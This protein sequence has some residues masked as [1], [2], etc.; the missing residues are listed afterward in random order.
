MQNYDCVGVLGAGSW[1]STLADLLGK[2]GHQVLLWLRNLQILQEINQHHGNSQYMGNLVL[3]DKITAI[4]DLQQLAQR[5][6]FMVAALP[7]PSLREIAYQLGNYIKGDQIL[8]SVCKGLEPGT[9]ARPA[10]ILAEETCARK[11]G[12]MSGPNL[13][14]EIMIGIPSATVI[15]SRYQEVIDKGRRY[16]S[17]PT[18][19]VY[20][21]HD[22][23]GVELGGIIKNVIAIAAGILDGLELG[24]N[25]KAIFITRGMKEMGMLGVKLGANPA[26]FT[27]LSGI[28][29]LSVSCSSKLSRNYRLGFFLARG[30]NLAQ[31]TA[32]IK[33]TIEG[34]NTCKVLYELAQEL[35]L[36]IPIIEGV[37][38]ILY[39]NR[40]IQ[41]V[42]SELMLRKSYFDKDTTLLEFSPPQSSRVVAE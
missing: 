31:A 22:I 2:N 29:D 35:H 42:V 4:Q 10:S 39:Q 11:I 38:H 18:F 3:S 24:A 40:N 12:V 14:A 28:G 6:E 13:A 37:Y 16:F 19:Q 32:E 15:A 9:H 36:E 7:A 25:T 26:T 17:S 27:G 1:G 41:E 8:L 21:S 5:C 34:V 23:V 33:T 30:K 20:G